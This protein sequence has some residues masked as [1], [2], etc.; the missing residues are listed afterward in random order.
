MSSVETTNGGDEKKSKDSSSGELQ[1]TKLLQYG[2]NRTTVNKVIISLVNNGLLERSQGVGTF[3]KE[4]KKVLTLGVIVSSMSDFDVRHINGEINISLLNGI[5]DCSYDKNVKTEVISYFPGAIAPHK[6]KDGF[7]ALVGKN[8]LLEEL[9]HIGLPHVFCCNSSQLPDAAVN[10]VLN[11]VEQNI[12]ACINYLAK[13]GNKRIA[14]I[15]R[16]S[17][18][19]RLDGYIRALEDNGLDFMPQLLVEREKGSIDDGYSGAKELWE[20]QEKFDSV[21]CS[22]DFRAFGA[23]NFFKEKCLKISNDI[24]VMGYDNILLS[25]ET[26]PAL[27]TFEPS[28]RE[29][30]KKALQELLKSIEDKKYKIGRKVLPGK[31][32]ER[33]TT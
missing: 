31:I 3:V 4:E 33:E 12:Y 18:D 2:V 32:V 27:T 13:R 29:R 11:D 15:G 17:E 10:A 19:K 21:F 1:N 14:Y 23:M 16:I 6:D 7:I 26:E 9:E 24:S 30:G 5:L 8:K 28:R 20:K 25:K 22:T